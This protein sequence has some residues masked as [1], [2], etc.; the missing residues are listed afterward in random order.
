M[1]T[2][3]IFVSITLFLIA[4]SNDPEEAIQE[5]QNLTEEINQDPLEIRITNNIN[6]NRIDLINRTIITQVPDDYSSK[7]T[8]SSARTSSR[9]F[10]STTPYESS[11]ANVTNDQ[12]HYWFWVAKVDAPSL[13][14]HTLLNKPKQL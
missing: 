5:T 13:E 11:E 8:N 7:S 6:Q 10:S 12:D 1:K 9:S 2:K 14:T 4:C 3:I